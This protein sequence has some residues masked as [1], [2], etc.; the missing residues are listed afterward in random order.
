MCHSH[1]LNRIRQ[2]RLH[3]FRFAPI[4][5]SGCRSI[6]R[7]RRKKMNSHLTSSDD[8]MKTHSYWNLKQTECLAV[9]LHVSSFSHLLSS[10]TVTIRVFLRLLIRKTCQNHQKSRIIR[11]NSTWN[12]GFILQQIGQ[13]FF[14][15]SPTS[16][17]WYF[18][19]HLFSLVWLQSG[20]ERQRQNKGKSI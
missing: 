7:S 20:A 1:I 3:N 14:L 16:K 5:F 9:Y 11:R 17:P 10:H 13:P 6:V 15:F 2:W 19:N 18:V 8:L 4:F 12:C